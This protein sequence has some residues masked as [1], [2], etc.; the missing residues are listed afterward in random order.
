LLWLLLESPLQSWLLANKYGY[1]RLGPN[2][3]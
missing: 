1:G 2:S 3:F